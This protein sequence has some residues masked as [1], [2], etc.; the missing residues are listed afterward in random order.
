MKLLNKVRTSQEMANFILTYPHK[1]PGTSHILKSI[2]VVIEPV[3]VSINIYLQYN[4]IVEVIKLDKNE[5]TTE[6]TYFKKLYTLIDN[7]VLDI[8][9]R[10]F[11]YVQGQ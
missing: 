1:K 6:A 8:K 5:M 11:R 9:D 10:Y 3:D 7:K 2:L 4:G